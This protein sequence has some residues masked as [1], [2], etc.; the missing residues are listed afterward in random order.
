VIFDTPSAAQY[1]NYPAA[2]PN[3]LHYVGTSFRA[4]KNITNRLFL[5]L[6][7]VPFPSHQNK[8]ASSTITVYAK[9]AK[10]KVDDIVQQAIPTVF[11]KKDSKL[12]NSPEQ[13]AFRRMLRYHD[14]K[15]FH[16]NHEI[17]KTD[18][19]MDTAIV[20]KE[21]SKQKCEDY[22][23]DNTFYG[24][25]AR[26]FVQEEL[27]SAYKT[28]ATRVFNRLK[29]VSLKLQILAPNLSKSTYANFYVIPKVH[30]TPI[31]ARPITSA[32]STLTSRV[33]KVAS[34]VLELL[35]ARLKTRAIEDGFDSALTICIHTEDAIHK[36]QKAFNLFHESKKYP[37]KHILS[38]SPYVGTD[39]LLAF[40]SYDFKNMYNNLDIK[41]SIFAINRLAVEFA[42]IDNPDCLFSVSF[43]NQTD[44][45][46]NP[47]IWCQLKN[48]LEPFLLEIKWK[49]VIILLRITLQ[50]FS[51]IVCDK[52]S[53][54]LFKQIRDIAMSTNCSPWVA[55]LSL[56]YY[57]LCY[58][59]SL[60]LSLPFDHKIVSK[61]I[62]HSSPSYVGT[63]IRIFLKWLARYIDDVFVAH[64]F[65]VDPLPILQKIYAPSGLRLSR[66]ANSACGHIV[67]LDVQFPSPQPSTTHL[68]FSL[69]CK[70]GTNYEYPHFN[71]FVPRSVHMGLI[72]GGFHRI[73]NRNS[74]L[75]QFSLAYERYSNILKQHGYPYVWVLK[76]FRVFL[77]RQ[78]SNK[79]Q[80][81]FHVI[82]DFQLKID[83]QLFHGIVAANVD[84][85]FAFKIRQYL[86]INTGR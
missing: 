13:R 68:S 32:F 60:Y 77:H 30:K 25:H 71:L 9:D 27:V 40:S 62:Q 23:L 74:H 49:K 20:S 1:D 43:S 46:F 2:S 73:F 17:L 26:F 11:S 78:A 59:K 41:A 81:S 18:K 52:I 4:H 54:V 53:L 44:S 3:M 50:E 84:K 31:D 76:I 37:N 42:G 36:A 80:V 10:T 16:R 39:T 65:S 45:D 22:L 24:I 57:E 19:N 5:R 66:S 64:P 7:F 82:M 33:S 56:V 70:P 61:R 48:L 83:M 85:R 79:K 34:D 72:L 35:F 12:W 14:W 6:N 28:H 86:N 63:D 67:F 29:H 8:Q 58:D 47:N 21:W 51:F 38:V 69:N 15:T 75:D 55:N